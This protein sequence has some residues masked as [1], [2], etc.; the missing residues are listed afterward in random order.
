MFN[1]RCHL[2]NYNCENNDYSK[3]FF[4]R[5]LNYYFNCM[6]HVFIFT[7]ILFFFLA[8]LPTNK[9]FCKTT[10]DVCLSTATCIGIYYP[11]CTK[12]KMTGEN[13]YYTNPCNVAVDN[14]LNKGGNIYFFINFFHLYLYFN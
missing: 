9:E 11:V 6:I 7:M 12:S 8:Y 4:F 13:V 3:C 2:E 1:N 10:P 14:C 5:M